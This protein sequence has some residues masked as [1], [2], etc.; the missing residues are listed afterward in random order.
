MHANPPGKRGRC[1]PRTGHRVH[2][3]PEA[4]GPAASAGGDNDTNGARSWANRRPSDRPAVWP[5]SRE[6]LPP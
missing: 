6:P 1:E 4:P 5:T 3:V 2:D